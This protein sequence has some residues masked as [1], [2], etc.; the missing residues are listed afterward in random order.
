MLS[1]CENQNEILFK[2]TY[3]L[4]SLSFGSNLLSRLLLSSGFLQMG[5]WSQDLSIKQLLVNVHMKN[6]NIIQSHIELKHHFHSTGGKR[7]DR[8]EEMCN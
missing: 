8:L 3:S 1:I 4:V 7:R 6:V 5:F 2:L